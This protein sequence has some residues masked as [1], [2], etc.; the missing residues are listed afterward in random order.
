MGD[1]VGNAIQK[2]PLV[3][4]KGNIGL[5]GVAE[6]ESRDGM[7]FRHSHSLSNVTM[8]FERKDMELKFCRGVLHN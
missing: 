7:D 6:I 4:H 2:D 5:I 3:S 1:E 8:T